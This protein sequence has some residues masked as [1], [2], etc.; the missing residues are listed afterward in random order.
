MIFTI[1]GH[2]ENLEGIANN[3][4]YMNNVDA[5]S[6]EEASEKFVTCMS[7][8]MNVKNDQIIIDRVIMN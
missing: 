2:S 4:L 5:I 8:K 7:I 3:N 6:E 1:L